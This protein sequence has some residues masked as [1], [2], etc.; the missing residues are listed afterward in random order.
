[1]MLAPLCA[2]SRHERTRLCLENSPASQVALI[3]VA[4]GHGEFDAPEAGAH[5]LP[6]QDL[7]EL[8]CVERV[9]ALMPS[10]I[11]GLLR[12]RQWR[13]GARSDFTASEGFTSSK[14][15]SNFVNLIAQP[16]A[17]QCRGGA[18]WSSTTRM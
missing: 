9:I 11:A 13:C 17:R 10:I 3:G 18:A 2:V 4:G 12:H 15:G 14:A 6:A 16:A 1:V 8:S 7:E 5:Q